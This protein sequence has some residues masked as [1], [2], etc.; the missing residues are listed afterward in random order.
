VTVTGDLFIHNSFF[1]SETAPAIVVGHTMGAVKEQSANLY[2]TKLAEQGSVTVALD[3]SLWGDSEGEPRNAKL[4]DVY[5]DFF[6]AAVDYLGFLDFVDRER[7]GAVGSCSSGS[8]V[9][10]ARRVDT[11]IVAIAMSSM[12]DIDAANSNRLRHAVSVGERKKMIAPVSE[13]RWV[14]AACGETKH[15]SDTPQNTTNTTDAVGRE[16]YYFYRTPRGELT[17]VGSSSNLIMHPTLSS[18]VK[19]LNF[20]HFNEIEIVFSRPMLFIFGDQA[21][22]CE[23]SEDAYA[24]VNKPKEL[25]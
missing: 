2:A 8:F 17:P 19:L 24:R 7:I 11:G 20:N 23:F 10:G 4:P 12:Y 14:E 21:Y 18:N 15:T 13:Q 3:V 6:S 5:A 1:R 9:N 16:S 25:V 22:S